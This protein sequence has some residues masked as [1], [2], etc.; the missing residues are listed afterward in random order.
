MALP[1]AQSNDGEINNGD[2]QKTECVIWLNRTRGHMAEIVWRQLESNNP[3]QRILQ[4][5]FEFLSLFFFLFFFIERNEIEKNCS[6]SF[7]HKCKTVLY[8]I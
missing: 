6:Q 1:E 4:G 8:I 2:K 3:S 7:K 5:I